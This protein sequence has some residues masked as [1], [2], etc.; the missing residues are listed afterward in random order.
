MCVRGGGRTMDG[1]V[2]WLGMEFGTEGS[3]LE[4]KRKEKIFGETTEI[5]C[6][7]DIV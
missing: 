6:L 2:D 4:R 3:R 5:R 1:W 7:S